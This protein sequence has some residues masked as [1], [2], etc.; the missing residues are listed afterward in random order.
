MHTY[1]RNR[2]RVL[3]KEIETELLRANPNDHVLE[4]L[5]QQVI[6]AQE[7]AWAFEDAE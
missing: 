3:E 7:K 4:R 1:W 5:A 6:D 2:V